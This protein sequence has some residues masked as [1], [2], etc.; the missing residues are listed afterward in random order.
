MWPVTSKQA[1]LI[2]VSEDGIYYCKYAQAMVFFKILMSCISLSPTKLVSTKCSHLLWFLLPKEERVLPQPRL[3]PHPWFFTAGVV[4]REK[5]SHPCG[6]HRPKVP[7]LICVLTQADPKPHSLKVLLQDVTLLSLPSFKD[8]ERRVLLR[9]TKKEKG[10]KS[11]LPISMFVDLTSSDPRKKRKKW[12][13]SK[14]PPPSEAK[15]SSLNWAPTAFPYPCLLPHCDAHLT[16]PTT[17]GV[18]PTTPSSSLSLP[19]QIALQLVV[20]FFTIPPSDLHLLLRGAQQNLIHRISYYT[21]TEVNVLSYPR[22][23]TF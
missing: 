11:Y 10:S 13:Q 18:P 19:A 23:L 14:G 4:P 20:V 1:L 8:V 16:P 7:P 9:L 22:A 5:T 6:L 17:P 15:R 12:S 21:L 2:T 3:T